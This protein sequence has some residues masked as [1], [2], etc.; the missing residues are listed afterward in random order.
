ML[1]NKKRF[2]PVLL[3]AMTM[4][5]CSS[6]DD[7]IE[8]TEP[9][10][11]VITSNL[12]LS[13]LS[14]DNQHVYVPGET[15]EITYTLH[16]EDID[17]QDV[18]VDFYVVHD[19]PGEEELED[20]DESEVSGD[21]FLGTT[22]FADVSTGDYDHHSSFTVPFNLDHEGNYWIMAVVD[23][24]DLIVESDE[25]DNH[26]HQDNEAHVEGDFP[27]AEV[28]VELHP[29]HEFKLTNIEIDGDTVLLDAPN[30]HEGTGEEHS[31]IIGHFDAIYHGAGEAKARFEAEV[32]IDGVFQPVKLWD[33]ESHSYV[34]YQD[35]E[36]T[37]N[38]EDHYF[39]YDIFISDEQ[40]AA[41]YASYDA[42]L[43]NHL[44]IRYDITDISE[45]NAIEHD[46][47]NHID[48]S[49]PLY[50]FEG[51][52]RTASVGKNEGIAGNNSY[53]AA[54]AKSSG[55]KLSGGFNK[56]YGDRKKVA[57]SADLHGLLEL[58]TQ[59][60]GAIADAGGSF[61][62]YVFNKKA[63]IFKVQYDASAY[64]DA[65]NTGYGSQLV[66]FGAK[67]IDES[68]YVDEFSK[69]W[70]R[71]WE[72]ERELVSSTFFV[73]PIP[74]SA[75]A[76]VEGSL[77]MDFTL[78]YN[79]RLNATGDI[80]TT[81]FDI[82]ASGGIE[83]GV[84][85]AGVT[86]R[87]RVVDDLLSLDSWAD[88]TLIEGNDFDPRIDYSF[89]LRNELEVIKGDF[90]LHAQTRSVKWCKKKKWGIKIKYPC[91]IKT[92]DYYY[93]FYRTS[94]LFNKNWTIF[95]KNGSVNL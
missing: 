84:A 81:T 9:V 56:T 31:D 82:F 13:A 18:T 12:T 35:I 20:T 70:E 59:D 16:A 21:H 49:Y 39:G 61:N 4:A 88:M 28:S 86:A 8:V 89:K 72:E 52:D 63:T 23:P 27:F 34:D 10:E 22:T 6:D 77:G 78:S 3:A 47:T 76:G 65:S 83:A 54:S 79:G 85:S 7:E 15:I 74:V 60:K 25:T 87:F 24:E 95:E 94:G 75:R 62:F 43:Y 57:A 33:A 11:P 38:G 45:T 5:G 50:F 40:R 46:P 58:N 37:Y 36:F 26:P 73:G 68:H 69:T 1:Q 48:V 17:S 32:L 92:N 93:W 2:L 90:G 64:L 66:L 19:E 53:S 44:V 55:F 30:Y 14:V 29:E 67:L 41:L 80:F 91:G 71:D 51:E 42:D